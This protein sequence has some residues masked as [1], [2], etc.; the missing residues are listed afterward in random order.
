MSLCV[1]GLAPDLPLSRCWQCLSTDMPHTAFFWEWQWH[2]KYT[3][4]KPGAEPVWNPSPTEKY[5]Q[6]NK[7]EE[8]QNT[9]P[10]ERN[11]PI[12]QNW[13]ILHGCSG[14]TAAQAQLRRATA[15]AVHTRRSHPYSSIWSQ[16]VTN[17][18]KHPY[19]PLTALCPALL[20]TLKAEGCHLHLKGDFAVAAAAGFLVF[21][22]TLALI[23][24]LLKNQK[25]TS[26]FF[27]A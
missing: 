24:Q 3:G 15:Q 13:C 4:D 22:T 8:L 12:S 18:L 19:L 21:V 6:K 2:Q 23:Y 1:T 5:P 14:H 16:T 9:E 7:K 20:D 10:S 26:R 17:L 27:R 11:W 25:F